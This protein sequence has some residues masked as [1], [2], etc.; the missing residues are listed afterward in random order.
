MT[1]AESGLVNSAP[2]DSDVLLVDTSEIVETGLAGILVDTRLRIVCRVSRAAAAL[3]WLEGRTPALVVAELLVD[4]G[5]IGGLVKG[6]RRRKI[7]LVVF[8]AWEHPEFIARA[9][10]DGA[11]GLISKW[12]DE[13][14][15]RD[16]MIRAAAGGQLWTRADSRRL[17]ASR[18]TK[19]LAGEIEF[20]LT[21]RELQ[22][23]R[24]MADGYS[25]RRIAEHLDIA[26][27]TAKEHVQ[28]V[29]ARLGVAGR[30]EA[31]ILA[32]RAGI[33]L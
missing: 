11:A 1:S 22:V 18:V 28:R 17:A 14:N 15:V 16:A 25:N 32:E 20:P 19:R 23:L 8:T 30:T 13:A 24:L 9:I 26:F 4:D 12:V 33:L 6:C 27:E 7:P 29:I 5:E 21:V 2:T 31:A 3:K 10:R